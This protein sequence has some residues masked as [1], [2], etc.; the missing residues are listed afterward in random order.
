MIK[1][2]RKLGLERN[3]LSLIKDDFEKLQL[4]SY[5]MVKPYFPS[6]IGNKAG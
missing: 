2:L 3:F 4:A 1:S 6:K 5:L